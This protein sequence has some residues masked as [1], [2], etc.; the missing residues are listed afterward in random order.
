NVT[1]L[2]DA[3]D[4]RDMVEAWFVKLPDSTVTVGQS[5]KK[6][7]VEG[8]KEGAEPEVKGEGV[9][10]LKKIETRGN[11]QIAFIEGKAILKINKETPAGDLVADGNVDMKA[12]VA[13]PG[14]YLIELKQDLE[15]RGNTVAKDTVTDKETKRQTALTRNTE[16]KLQQ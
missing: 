10:T 15:I 11:I 3:N 12:Q 13:V 7:I 4:L 6:P 16:I 14:G 1:G 8:K 5:W 9:F 2:R